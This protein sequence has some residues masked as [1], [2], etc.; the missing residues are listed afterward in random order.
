MGSSDPRGSQGAKRHALGYR[1]G[2][3]AEARAIEQRD[4]AAR[5]AKSARQHARITQGQPAGQA[6]DPDQRSMAD[7][8]SLDPER[9]E[10][11][12]ITDY[13]K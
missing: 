13:H 7:R 11:V 5:F 10:E 9:T 4:D 6:L 8:F 2:G 3:A 12:E 1:Q